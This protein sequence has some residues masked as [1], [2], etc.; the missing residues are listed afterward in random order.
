MQRYYRTVMDASLLNELLLQLFSE[1]I[2]S[3]EEDI[4]R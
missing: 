4:R 2:L 1:A 3:K